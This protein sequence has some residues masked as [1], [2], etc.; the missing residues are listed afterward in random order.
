MLNKPVILH[1]H[2][3]LSITKRYGKYLLNRCHAHVQCRGENHLLEPEE[4][5][6]L[7]RELQMSLIVY[8]QPSR[9]TIKPFPRLRCLYM[10]MPIHYISKALNE[11]PIEVEKLRR[12]SRVDTI[13]V[14]PLLLNNSLALIPN[15]PPFFDRISLDNGSIH[16]VHPRI[17]F[18]GFTTFLPVTSKI[19]QD[20]QLFTQKHNPN[21]LD[22]HCVST[23][24]CFENNEI[25]MPI[26]ILGHLV[27][28]YDLDQWD[29]VKPLLGKFGIPLGAVYLLRKWCAGGTNTSLRHMASKVVIV[30]VL[31]SS[32][33]TD[34]RE[35][36]RVLAQQPLKNWL[37]RKLKSC[38]SCAT[39]RIRGL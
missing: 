36:R 22:D 28:N 38:F 29:V 31:P 18:I 23:V 32:I 21:F 8:Y 14:L 24:P 39:I 20:R 6:G 10:F 12:T 4:S 3:P 35:V 33:V 9:L 2:L 26:G 37:N 27:K 1:M 17:E 34:D 11:I 19:S 13:A 5:S 7:R 16:L 15:C 30:T 25:D